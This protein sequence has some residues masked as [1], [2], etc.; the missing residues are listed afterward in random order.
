MYELKIITMHL[1]ELRTVATEETL[2]DIEDK[3]RIYTSGANLETVGR[4]AIFHNGV[5]LPET[6]WGR[7]PA[8]PGDAF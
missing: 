4:C 1:N 7:T 5:L 3:K 2:A 8:R 6:I